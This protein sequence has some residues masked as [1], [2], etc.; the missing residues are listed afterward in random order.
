VGQKIQKNRIIPSYPIFYEVVARENPDDPNSRLMGLGRFHAEIWVL[1]LVDLDFANF[2]KAQLNT[3]R[4]MF[5]ALFPLIFLIIV[6]YFSRSVK[7]ELLDYFYAKI[8]TPLQP[9]PEQDAALIQENVANMEKF[10]SRKLFR[11]TQWEFHKPLKM[12]YIGFFG[13]WGLVGVVIL[14]MWIFMN[15]GG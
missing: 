1:S 15:L 11:R 13:T 3:V 9:T 7:K 8:H 5:D 6:S 12:D 2:N 14:V 10:E 4:F